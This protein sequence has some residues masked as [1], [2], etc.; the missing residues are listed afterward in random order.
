LPRSIAFSTSICL[1]V[2]L[3]QA[4]RSRTAP[5]AAR[6]RRRP[7]TSTSTD[8]MRSSRSPNADL[9]EPSSLNVQPRCSMSNFSDFVN[10]I[11]SFTCQ[12]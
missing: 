11:G 3:R 8:E 6:S 9:S 7:G 1:R 12:R 10:G 2:A 5:A 4:A